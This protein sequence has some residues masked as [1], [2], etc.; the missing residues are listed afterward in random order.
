MIE[1]VDYN[2]ADRPRTFYYIDNSE[3]PLAGGNNQLDFPGLM[4][5][6]NTAFAFLEYLLSK[7]R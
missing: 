7:T 1:E 2:I 5:C 3:K 6:V 4:N